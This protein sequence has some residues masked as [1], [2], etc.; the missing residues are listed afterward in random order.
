MNLV[1]LSLIL[2][3]AIIH[4]LWN[5]LMKQSRD[6]LAFIWWSILVILFIYFP[7]FLWYLRQ[8]S[9]PS[10]ENWFWAMVSGFFQA[11]YCVLLSFAYEQGDLSI[12]YP[13][14]RGSAPIFITIGAILLLAEQLS[15]T[16]DRH[17]D[18]YIRDLYSSSAFASVF[19]FAQTDSLL[20]SERLT[21]RGFNWYNNRWLPYY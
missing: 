17:F 3:S 12:I 14:S 5:L 20:D 2:I 1:A 21:T 11:L 16:G 4:A 9:L 19:R 8:S 7:L 18:R 15:L 10:Q 13:L 6:K